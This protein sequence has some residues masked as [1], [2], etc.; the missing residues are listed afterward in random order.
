M[1]HKNEIDSL[2]NRTDLLMNNNSMV[3]NQI[4]FN[5]K[6]KNAEIDSLKNEI[7]LLKE[8]KNKLELDLENI[9]KNFNSELIKREKQNE[10]MK[11][12]KLKVSELGKV[13]INETYKDILNE[14]REQN[15]KSEINNEILQLE[16]NYMNI[17]KKRKKKLKN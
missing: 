7:L 6:L 16:K 12:K 13:E 9:K 15:K 14:L 8:D 17:G 1:Q 10:K 4:E 2:R 5:L 11:E 3:N